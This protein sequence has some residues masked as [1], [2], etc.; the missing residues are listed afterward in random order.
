[1]ES[2]KPSRALVYIL[3]KMGLTARFSA[4]EK[5][6]VNCIFEALSVVGQNYTVDG[7][8]RRSTISEEGCCN[9]PGGVGAG[10]GPGCALWM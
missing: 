3:S 7:P 9:N 2:F 6:D 10:L 4:W 8:D 5:H 1:M